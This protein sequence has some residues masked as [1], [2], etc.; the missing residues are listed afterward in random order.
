MTTLLDRALTPSIQPLR[1]TGSRPVYGRGRPVT[2]AFRLADTTRGAVPSR[3]RTIPR[4]RTGFNH[5]ASARAVHDPEVH[6]D[7]LLHPA[8][9]RLR[10]HRPRRG[11]RGRLLA[12]QRRRLDA[13]GIRLVGSRRR[14]DRDLR[15]GVRRHGRAGRGGQEGGHAQR[16]RAAAGLGQLRRDHQGLQAK[17]GIKVNSRQPDATSQDEINAAKQLKG[18]A[19]A[20]RTSSTSAQRWRWPTPT[21]FAPY[22]VAT[23][24]DIP[25][26][27]KDAERHLGQRLR[28][29][30]VDRL[31]RRQGAG[32]D[33]R[34]R[35]AQARV[36]GQGRAQRRPDPG[37]RRVRRRA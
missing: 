36:Q 3:R 20:P 18:Q 37:R 22:K 11:D 4:V 31:R 26:E 24:D 2:F 10:H 23:L 25:A 13:G 8:R 17:Y 9:R 5:E 21:M 15:R 12:A 35:P 34:R 30:H 1:D 29:L 32:A 14:E 28:R 33:Q 27:L 19:T 6:D 7:P 16:H